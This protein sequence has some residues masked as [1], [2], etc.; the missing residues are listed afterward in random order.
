MSLGPQSSTASASE[1]GFTLK[2]KV[3]WQ[4][5]LSESIQQ[6]EERTFASEL[7]SNSGF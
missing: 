5:A 3:L 1:R 2:F 7:V 4:Q 6:E